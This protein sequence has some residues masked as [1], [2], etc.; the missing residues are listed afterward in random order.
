MTDLERE[1]LLDV[2]LDLWRRDISAD[3]ALELI[4]EILA[5]VE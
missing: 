3:N 5:K 4:E 1:K 2:L